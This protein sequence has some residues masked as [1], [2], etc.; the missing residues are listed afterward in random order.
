MNCEF[1]VISEMTAKV[2]NSKE[3]R[4][5]TQKSEFQKTVKDP[6]TAGR[7]YTP[8]IEYESPGMD[9][10]HCVIQNFHTAFFEGEK[11]K[12]QQQKYGCSG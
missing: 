6:S 8:E 2:H 9:L 4:A 12:K 10:I 5:L 11:N 3:R 1:S 7:D